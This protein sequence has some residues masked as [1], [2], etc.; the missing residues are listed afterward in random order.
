M[1]TPRGAL[2]Y[3]RACA[4]ADGDV[5]SMACGLASTPSPRVASFLVVTTAAAL[6]RGA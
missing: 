3:T 5:A 6:S 2:W 1:K 4:R